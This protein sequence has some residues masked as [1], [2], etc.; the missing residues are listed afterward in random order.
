MIAIREMK[1]KIQQLKYL[2]GNTYTTECQYL[3]VE[4]SVQRDLITDGDLR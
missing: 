3:Y 4:F 1:L 2:C